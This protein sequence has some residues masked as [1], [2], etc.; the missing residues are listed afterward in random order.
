MNCQD[1]QRD[2]D[3]FLDG[4]LADSEYSAMA[5]HIED[6]DGC[7]QAL[8][9]TRQLRAA[10][11]ELPA[12]PPRSGFARSALRQ[13]R[14]AHEQPGKGAAG[15][16]AAGFGSAAAAG[17][18][19]WLVVAPIGPV[20]DSSSGPAANHPPTVELA[21]GRTESVR[22]AF[23]APERLEGARL[24][25]RLPENFELAGY[26]QRREISWTTELE[27]GRNL[28]ELP[29]RALAGGEGEL[30]AEIVHGSTIKRL[31]IRLRAEGP[32]AFLAPNTAPT[33]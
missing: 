29:V 17:L 22:L 11:A 33:A 10:L 16:F 30:V 20:P 13:A 3:E 14:R 8:E 19:A 12:P 27:A 1:V 2:L 25:M 5:A 24:T 9:Q 26:S 4:T 15:W 31:R 28:L 23:D 21:P 6:C 32:A 18:A 7:R